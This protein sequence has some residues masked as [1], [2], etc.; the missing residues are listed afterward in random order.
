MDKL[1]LHVTNFTLLHMNFCRYRTPT[2]YQ[3]CSS[4]RN[5]ASC[6]QPMSELFQKQKEAACV[7]TCMYM[8]MHVHVHVYVHAGSTAQSP[9]KN[10]HNFEL[11]VFDFL[12][13]FAMS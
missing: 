11:L 9:E 6:T 7:C 1:Q 4:E 10:K 5:Q 12:F 2:M 13:D 8:Y 3:S